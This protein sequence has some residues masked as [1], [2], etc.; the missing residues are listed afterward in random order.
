MLSDAGFEV[1]EC[2]DL[3]ESVMPNVRILA[4]ARLE[5]MLEVAGGGHSRERATLWQ[6]QYDT[7]VRA[8]S[9]RRFTVGRFYALAL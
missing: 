3:A 5:L 8:W 1:R 9:E 2:V 6:Q 7:L 4:R